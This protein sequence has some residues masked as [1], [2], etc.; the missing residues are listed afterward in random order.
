MSHVRPEINQTGT[1]SHKG[2]GVW[3]WGRLTAALA[4]ACLAFLTR[5]LQMSRSN[6]RFS[7]RRLSFCTGE[8]DKEEVSDTKPDHHHSPNTS[9]LCYPRATCIHLVT[10]PLCPLILLGD[11]F[12]LLLVLRTS[13]CLLSEYPPTNWAHAWLELSMWPPSLTTLQQFEP[14]K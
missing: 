11:I 6:R 14:I 7:R 10:A 9:P 3:G 1:T 5:A 12:A 4:S 13:C 8:E 2:R